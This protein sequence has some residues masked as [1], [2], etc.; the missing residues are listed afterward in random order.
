MSGQSGEP[1]HLDKRVPLSLILALIAQTGAVFWWASGIEARLAAETNLNER[2]GDQIE[3]L[4]EETKGLTVSS[5]TVTAQL[6][7]VSQTLDEVKA[8]Q[9]EMNDLLRSIMA[10]GADG[11]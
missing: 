8:A 10:T 5:A 2:Q 6:V 4:R 11:Q 3:T 1:W 9:R 7:A